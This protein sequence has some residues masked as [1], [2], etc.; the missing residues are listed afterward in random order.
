MSSTARPS[1]TEIVSDFRRTQILDAARQSFLRHGIA[2]A[3]VEGI[4]RAAGVAKGTVY[5]YYKSKEDI[6]R[7]LLSS[8]LVEFHDETV[9]VPAGSGSLEQRLEQFLRAVFAFFDRKRDFFELCQTE[10]SPDV[11]KKAKQKLGMVFEAQADAWREV[12]AR[13]V[14]D[15]VIQNTDVAGAARGI[16]C[17]AH[18]IAHHRKRGWY[19][20]SI[21]DAVAW[22]VPLIL[23]G[24]L[25]R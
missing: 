22:A 13:G 10:M 16:V 18:G 25:A 15:G 11:R 4:A 23:Q 12:L 14:S 3:T 5:L 21:D 2:G 1:K 8:D 17:L 6:L 9:Q 19:S 24:V 7:Q 20:G